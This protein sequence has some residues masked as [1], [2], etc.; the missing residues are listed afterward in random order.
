MTSPPDWRSELE[1]ASRALDRW[2]V[3][4]ARAAAETARSLAAG[5][6]D[7]TA[8]ALASIASMRAALLTS[9]APSTQ[10]LLPLAAA[11]D[12]PDTQL[13][14]AA[15]RLHVEAAWASRSIA[16]LPTIPPL[17]ARSPVDRIVA[18]I[19]ACV[20]RLDDRERRP[21]S[22]AGAAA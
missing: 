6:G 17:T 4:A 14:A 12:D 18:S 15:L 8:A 22:V 20:L 19:F 9:A 1:K 16:A 10:P 21:P 3:A 7:V 11:G 13:G 5:W 2:E